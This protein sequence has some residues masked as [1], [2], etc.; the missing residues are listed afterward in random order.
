M[1]VS[2]YGLHQANCVEVKERDERKWIYGSSGFSQASFI[3]HQIHAPLL[4]HFTLVAVILTS[5]QYLSANET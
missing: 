2:L 5:I 1:Y 4:A 3:I